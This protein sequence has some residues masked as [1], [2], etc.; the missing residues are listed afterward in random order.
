M[1]W[2]RRSR[3]SI[4]TVGLVALSSFVGSAPLHAQ[5][6]KTA[7]AAG[8]KIKLESTGLSLAPADAAFFSASINL[9]KG[10]EKSV[11]GGFIAEVRQVPYV[12]QLEAFL[13][14]QWKKDRPETRQAKNFL[15]SPIVR[16]I[17]LLLSDMS[18]QECFV[19]GDKSWCDFANGFAEFQ[20]DMAGLDTDDSDAVREYI[21]EIQKED[22]DALPV[23]TT[24]FGFQLTED[25]NARTQLDALE[26]VLQL[27]LGQIEQLKPIAKGLKRKDLAN[28]QILSMTFQADDIPWEALPAPNDEAQEILDHFAELL[29]GRKFV[30]SMGVISN[31]LLICISD[32]ADTLLKLGKDGNLLGSKAMKQLASNLPEDLRGISFTSGEMRSAGMNINFGN[33]FE[34]LALAMTAAINKEADASEKLADWQDKLL[35]DCQWLDEQLEEILPDFGDM[36]SYTFISPEGTETFAYDWTESTTLQNATPM[37]VTRHGGTSP[38]VL[39]ASRQ[40]WIKQVGEMMDAVLEELPEHV[41]LLADSGIIE[42]DDDLETFKRIAGKVLPIIDDMYSSARDKVIGGMDGNESLVS[43]TALTTVRSLGENAPP[44]PEPLPLAEVG[45]VVKIKNKDLFLAGCDDIIQGINALIDIARE[46]GPGQVPPS[47]KVPPAKEESLAGGGTRYSFPM[48]LPAPWDQFELQMAINNEVAVLGYSTRQVRDLYQD[49]A[50]AARPAWYAPNQPNCGIGFVDI[51]GIFRSLK[52]WVH[53]GL[54]SGTGDINSP[55]FPPAGEAP[56]MTGADVL[57]IWS[58]F[59]KLGKCAG[60]THVDKNNVTI[61]HWIWVGE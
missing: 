52:P 40:K 50:L 9:R 58:C 45:T 2:Y 39:L 60:T 38:L 54:V 33:Y 14:D 26:G 1:D 22:I 59:D 43:I 16:D 6:T 37:A 13:I 55:L 34:R 41:D 23:P 17:L 28:G 61:T 18:S 56:V 19:F 21:L 15:S 30:L 11:E 24:V 49:R 47:A 44:P 42:N 3:V 20:Y 29:E 12:Q 35:E 48:G 32:S 10:F 4:L 31:R 8:A 46:E 5:A 7:P 25:G 27:A 57:Q 36:L 53:Y 51:A